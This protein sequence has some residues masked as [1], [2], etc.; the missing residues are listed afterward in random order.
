M[1]GSNIREQ[2]QIASAEWIANLWDEKETASALGL[3]NSKT[4][5]VWRSTKRHQLKYYRFGRTIRYDPSDVE[6]F[7]RERAV[8]A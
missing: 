8:G 4:L 2:R 7:I 6:E 3:K 5:A 1:S